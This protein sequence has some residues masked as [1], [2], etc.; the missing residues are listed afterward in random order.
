V[1]RRFN[2][3]IA[4][5]YVIPFRVITPAPAQGK[6]GGGLSIDPL[7]MYN[8]ATSAGRSCR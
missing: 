3:A 2:E 7:Q 4:L 6:T 8:G 1:L 5:D